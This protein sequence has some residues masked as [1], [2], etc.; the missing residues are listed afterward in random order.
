MALKMAHCIGQSDCTGTPGSRG[1]CTR[2]YYRHQRAGTLEN[3]PTMRERTRVAR[4]TP[5]RTSSSV[6]NRRWRRKNYEQ[7]VRVNGHLVHPIDRH[8]HHNTY[9]GYGCRGPMCADSQ[10]WYRSTG[11]TVIPI[12]RGDVRLTA[13]QC[14]HYVS[15][16]R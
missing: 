3:F 16:L 6:L 5:V 10:R 14:A 15:Q 2:C 12:A 1:L 11:E 8:G 9:T 4:A 13:E 7:R